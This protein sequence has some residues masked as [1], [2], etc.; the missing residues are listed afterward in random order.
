MP[1][2]TH[3]AYFATCPPAVRE[4]LEQLQAEV[5]RRIPTAQ[6]CV[7]YQ[8]AAFKTDRVFFY[9]GAFKHHIGV[10]PP[11]TQDRILMAET[12]RFRGPKGNLSFPLSEPLPLGLVGRVAQA[13]LKEYTSG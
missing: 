12:A 7:S 5:E 9:F 11:V 3:E 10:Y 1:F 13:L 8:L 6:R 2:A 4:R